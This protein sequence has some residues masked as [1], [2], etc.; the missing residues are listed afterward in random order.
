MFVAG[1][2]K[3]RLDKVAD[4]IRSIGGV[5]DMAVVDALDE[6][7]VDR[8]VDAVVEKAGQIDISF[9]V[10][11][12]G[13]VQKPL[14]E[15]SVEAFIQPIMIATRAQFLTTR[16][17]ARHMVARGSGVILAFGGD[18]PQTI[19]ETESGRD[20]INCGHQRGNPAQ[21]GGDPGRR[22]QCGIVR[23]LRSGSH[24]DRHRGQHLLRGI[25]RLDLS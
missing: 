13:D 1:R 6:S 25:G 9:N 7:A 11:S 8:F 10:I 17:A 4:E 16:A 20:E 12:Y 3:A 21:A 14:T 24:F 2:T 19:P 18:G 23:R 5:A 22:W 15:I